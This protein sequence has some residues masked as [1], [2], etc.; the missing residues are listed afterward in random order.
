MICP[1]C[2]HNDTDVIDSR[3]VD[4]QSIRR[5]RECGKC[6]YRF[7]TYENIE[8]IKISVLKR[9]G[10]IEPYS[11][12]KLISGM[13]KATQKRNISSDKLEDIADRI[14]QKL[15]EKNGNVCAS[16]AIGQLA[17]KELKK[18]DKVAYIRFASVYKNF[19]SCNS[20]IKEAEQLIHKEENEP[21]R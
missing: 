7:T 20:F 19:S 11:R 15:I 1:R 6:K 9:D 3:D 5:R 4:E 18:L 17:I 21:N 12:E 13:A 16:R 14:E 2:Q 8:P 10:E